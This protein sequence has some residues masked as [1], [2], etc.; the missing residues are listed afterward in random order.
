[1]Q[2]LNDNPYTAIELAAH[3]DRVGSQNYNLDLSQRRAESVVEYLISQGI[4]EDRLTPVG[5]GKERPKQVDEKLHEQYDF[6]PIGQMLDEEFVNSLE[7]E[8]REVADQVN[9]RTEFQVT[10]TTW[11]IE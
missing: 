1:M 7:P 5:Y 9:R 2:L 10:S 4:D 3:T 6:L 11:G 8:Q